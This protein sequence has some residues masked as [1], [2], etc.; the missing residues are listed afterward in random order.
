MDTLDRPGRLRERIVAEY[1]VLVGEIQEWGG[2]R[3]VGSLGIRPVPEKLGCALLTYTVVVRL[4][5]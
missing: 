4:V 5:P 2:V 3:A 1:S